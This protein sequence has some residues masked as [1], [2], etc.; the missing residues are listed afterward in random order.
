MK[1]LIVEDQKYPL[2]ALEL[3]VKRV[4]P[5]FYPEFNPSQDVDIARSYFFAKFLSD[6]KFDM[7]LLDHR[8]PIAYSDLE[9]R[10][11]EAFSASLQN[12][13]YSLIPHLKKTGSI[14]IGTSSLSPDELR[15]FTQPDFTLNKL[16]AEADL[17]RILKEIQGRQT[18]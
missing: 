9:D 8:L 3:A 15:G 18:Q 16:N 14:V 10:D 11:F 1:I 2:E 5:G 6:E 7:A 4:V 13:G 17:E 12:I